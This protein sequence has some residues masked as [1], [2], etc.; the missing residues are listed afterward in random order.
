M[1]D[2]EFDL[3]RSLKVKSNSAVRLLIYHFLLVSNSNHMCICHRIHVGVEKYSSISYN[4]GQIVDQLMGQN[5]SSYLAHGQTNR[6][7]IA[8]YCNAWAGFNK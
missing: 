7:T 2:L 6:H 8:K 5:F 3:S 1:S 4:Q